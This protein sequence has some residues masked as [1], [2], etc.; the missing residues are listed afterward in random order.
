MRISEFSAE[1][2]RNFTSLTWRPGPGLNIIHG[3]NGQGKTNLAEGLYFL[4]HLKS[5]RTT[6]LDQLLQMGARQGGMKG[7]VEVRGLPRDLR[8]ELSR[9]G[10][11]VWQDGQSITKTSEYISNYFAIAFNPDALYSF[12]NYPQERRSFF[13]RVFSFLDKPY[14]DELRNFRHIH[15]Q[16]N[17]LLKNADMRSLPEWNQL[18]IESG[19]AL[20]RMRRGWVEKINLFLPEPYKKIKGKNDRISLIFNPGIAYH[21][22]DAMAALER[23]RESERHVGHALYGPHRDDYRLADIAGGEMGAMADG[24]PGGEAAQITGVTPPEMQPEPGKVVPDPRLE[25]PAP[26]LV[27][28]PGEPEQEM[29]PDA[30][31]SQGEYRLAMVAML[32]AMAALLEEERGFHP[33]IILDDLFSELDQGVAE[34]LTEMLN[35]LPNQVFIT[36]A[37]APTAGRFQGAHV[38]KIEH[39][40]FLEG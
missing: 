11:R 29:R 17:R 3:D 26:G 21:K 22:E 39:G 16:K 14:L 37:H 18:F 28:A 34:R 23:L 38:K 2:F 20:A 25:D 33:L 40:A 19:T 30:Y 13:D 27:E 5:F 9:R 35:G 32:L 24:A 4:C 36:T 15:A 31:F 12:R 8:V 10:R 6:R 1:G 7:Q